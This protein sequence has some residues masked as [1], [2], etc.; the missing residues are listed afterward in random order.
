MSLRAEKTANVAAPDHLF[1]EERAEILAGLRAEQKSIEPKYFYDQRGSELFDE[2]CELPEYYPTR[3]E[4]QIM[5]DHADE[6]AALVGPKAAII[7]FGAGSNAKARQLLE[8]LETPVAYVPVEISGDYLAEQAAELSRDLPGLSIQPVVADFTKPF[9][10]PAHPIEPERNVIFFPGSTIGNFT[11]PQ[12]VDLLKVMH[13]EAKSGGALLIGVDLIKNLSTIRRA[14]N[15]SSGVTAAFNRN[16]LHHLNDGLGANFRPELFRHEAVY[17]T[18]LDRIEMRLI[19]LEP[20][21]VQIDGE[22][23]R[24][25]RGEHIVTEYSHKYSIEGFIELAAR[26]GW[27]HGKTWID[28]DKLFSVH[29]L[30]VD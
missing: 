8:R 7:E 18:D 24:F 14:Y 29:F 3:T 10:L 17:D 21:A 5:A 1:A 6:I 15:D 20:H 2:I 26:A 4:A 30:T 22:S 12:A 9:D 23:I 28:Q 27:R 19:S 13:T 16:V 11:R 25:K